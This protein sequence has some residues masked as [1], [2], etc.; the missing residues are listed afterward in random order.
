MKTSFLRAGPNLR[1]AF[2][3]ST[4]TT[5]ELVRNK[6]EWNETNSTFCSYPF[7]EAEC[8]GEWQ[9]AKCF[10]Q[11]GVTFPEI[12]MN[13][14]KIWSTVQFFPMY[15]T[16]YTLYQANLPI[17]WKQWNQKARENWVSGKKS[18]QFYTSSLSW[19]AQRPFSK[20]ENT[21][22]MLHRLSEM[23]AA[24][25]PVNDNYLIFLTEISNL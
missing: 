19:G 17:T 7:G 8:E 5:W 20:E 11:G 18:L 24:C 3:S 22:L 6:V 1:N 21:L 4:I 15:L 13:Y 2:F 16:A 23:S 25:M 14:S 9:A 12:T 10:A